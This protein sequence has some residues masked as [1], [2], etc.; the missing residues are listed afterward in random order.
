MSD[1]GF[2]RV[3]TEDTAGDLELRSK[4]SLRH[5]LSAY[6]LQP[7]ACRLCDEEEIEPQGTQRD[8]EG[9]RIEERDFW[10]L[11]VALESQGAKR[12]RGSDSDEH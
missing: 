6:S 12:Q 3:A 11:V 9:R 4:R 5:L 10:I 1:F 8:A 2:W 7:P